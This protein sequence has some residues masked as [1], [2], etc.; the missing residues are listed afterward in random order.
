V[1]WC[2]TEL[3]HGDFMTKP[4]QGTLFTSTRDQIVGVSKPKV[5]DKGKPTKQEK[6]RLA[7]LKKLDKDG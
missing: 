7:K 4:T 1:E 5:P 6:A 2:P 3:M